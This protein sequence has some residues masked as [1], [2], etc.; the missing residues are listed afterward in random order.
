M[1]FFKM[2]YKYEFYICLQMLVCPCGRKNC[3]FIVEKL[4]WKALSI[5]RAAGL[6]C[7]GHEIYEGHKNF[8]SKYEKCVFWDTATLKWR[9][10]IS[11]NMVK[12][13]KGNVLFLFLEPFSF[14]SVGW[15]V[16][17]KGVR[18]GDKC[19]CIKTLY[20]TNKLK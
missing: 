19:T 18:R 14:F 16:S 4:L 8:H 3:F 15:C 13:I 5:A 7:S 10:H 20:L 2:K 6:V 9:K 17:S 12:I 1:R 11:I